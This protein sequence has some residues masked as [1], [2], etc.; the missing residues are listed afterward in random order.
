MSPFVKEGG[1]EWW[2]LGEVAWATRCPRVKSDHT[3]RSQGGEAMQRSLREESHGI[4]GQD[5]FPKVLL[6]PAFLQLVKV[7]E[8]QRTTPAPGPLGRCCATPPPRMPAWG[9]GKGLGWPGYSLGSQWATLFPL[10][11]RAQLVLQLT[12]NQKSEEF[13]LIIF[14]E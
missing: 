5:F 7:L 11:L 12:V 4:S 3:L 6:L 14:T 10:C 13:S 2:A 8:P 1:R 9:S